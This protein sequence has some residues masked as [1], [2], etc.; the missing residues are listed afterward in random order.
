MDKYFNYE[1]V[2]E[3]EKVIH[4]VTRVKG[5]A[6]L[7]WDELEADK[8]SKLKQNINSWDRML[9]KLKEKLMPKDY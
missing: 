3:E 7:W 8:R 2:E 1:D 5:N 6:T 4:L 9:A